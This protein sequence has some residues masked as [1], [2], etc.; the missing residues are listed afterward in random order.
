MNNVN[1]HAICFDVDSTLV[2]C[3]GLDWLAELKGVGEEVKSLTT[4]AMNGEVPMESVFGKKLD[5]IRPS[6]KELLKVGEYYC[7]SITDGV[8]EVFDVLKQLGVD[9]WL[10]TGSFYDAL[11][12]LADRLQIPRDKIHANDVYFDDLG[13]YQGINLDCTLTKASGKAQCAKVIGQGR[14]VAFIGDSVTDLATKPVVKTFVG[15][16][17]V[18][19]R[20]KVKDEAEFF[21]K[22]PSLAPL[23]S[24]VY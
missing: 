3:E 13:N 9:I 22:S 7:S 1:Y 19:T 5:I 2:T 18:V 23:L 21:I 14:E 8:E 17:G 4:K 11:Y 24:L 20:Q 12:P 16:G 6:Q 10:V 15:F